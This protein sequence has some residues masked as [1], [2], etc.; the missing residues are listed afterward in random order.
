MNSDSDRIEKP[1]A[2]I[3]LQVEMAKMHGM[4]I[5]PMRIANIAFHSICSHSYDNMSKL[6]AIHAT[7]EY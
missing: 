7:N 6:Y 1:H 4:F 5:G 2:F 3:F